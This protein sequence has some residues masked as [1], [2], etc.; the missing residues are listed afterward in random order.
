MDDF[1]KLFKRYIEG[2]Q[3][4]VSWNKIGALPDKVVSMYVFQYMYGLLVT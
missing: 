2:E 3:T 4:E 1:F